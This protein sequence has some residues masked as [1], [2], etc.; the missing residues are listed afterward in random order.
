[1]VYQT[2][3]DVFLGENELLTLPLKVLL[4]TGLIQQTSAFQ[5]GTNAPFN[6][7]SK[8]KSSAVFE[9]MVVSSAETH[10]GRVLQQIMDSD[11]NKLA[12]M[13]TVH[14]EILFEA[15]DELKGKLTSL[16]E[17]IMDT[18]A[19]DHQ[20]QDNSSTVCA[21][22]I[23][24]D[25]LHERIIRKLDSRSYLQTKELSDIVRA[26]INL[27]NFDQVFDALRIAQQIAIKHGFELTKQRNPKRQLGPLKFGYPRFHIH[28]MHADWPINCEI[29]FGTMAF[30]HVIDLM[31][32][33]VRNP[34]IH[35]ALSKLNF[36]A[37]LHDIDYKIFR[38]IL[39][40][41]QDG[42]HQFL[43][44]RNILQPIQTFCDELDEFSGLLG[45]HGYDV[46]NFDEQSMMI[47]LKAN[48]LLELIYAN[49][50]FDYL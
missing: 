27:D 5:H 35:Q 44:F 30:E 32:V 29:Q 4:A 22:G 49:G 14:R 24:Q 41:F 15:A 39:S 19:L 45:I 26:R 3:C 38:R 34:K 25:D 28:I 8:V 43:V 12:N 48:Q 1:M 17:E 9:P 6:Q 36:E 46:E 10:K 20:L 50:L 13:P 31:Q 42:H 47:L 2:D 18:L 37:N 33:P 16:C 21:K 7:L 40:K 23:N 11:R